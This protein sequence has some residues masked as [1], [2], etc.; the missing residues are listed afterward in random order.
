ML[1]VL[2]ST[3][4]ENTNNMNLWVSSAA[5]KT[6]IITVNKLIRRKEAVLVSIIK[7]VGH[8]KFSQILLNLLLT[9]FLVFP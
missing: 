2:D 3:V 6:F 4:D 8:K 7:N 5:S 9:G 1:D